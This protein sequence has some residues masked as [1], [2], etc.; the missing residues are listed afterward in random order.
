MN[1][2]II[3]LMQ[4]KDTTMIKLFSKKRKDLVSEKPSV[5]RTTNYLKYAI[6]E[7]VLVVIG[8]L[9]ALQINNWNEQ[10]KMDLKEKSVLA[11]IHK[12]FLQNKIQLDT[13][14]FYHTRAMLSCKKLMAMFPIDIKKSNLDSIGTNLYNLGYVY[15]FNPSQGSINSIINTSSFDIIHNPELRNLLI[16]WPD[17]VT[18]YQEDEIEARKLV[19]ERLDP[20]LSKNFDFNYSFKDKRNHLEALEFLEFE[21][22]IQ[23]RY[24]SIEDIIGAHISQLPE[25]TNSLNEI[26]RLSE[27]EQP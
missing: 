1:L 2:L 25:L 22:L 18:D 21:Y 24:L 20:F 6:G 19:N 23:L 4:Q 9:L 17:L 7:I 16:S 8:I 26:I 11:A 12:E 14:L 27:N 15:T 3:L 13:V 10:R 5:S